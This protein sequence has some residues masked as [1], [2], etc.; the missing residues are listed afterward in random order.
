M[1]NRQQRRKLNKKVKTKLTPEEYQD[2]KN[3]VL[4]E[5]V[6]AEVDRRVK[7]MFESL[8]N[9]IIQSMKEHKIS[10]ARIGKIVD[11]VLEIGEERR[12]NEARVSE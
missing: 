9:D 5:T 10:E 4:D 1:A 11:R 7:E 6:K 12:K 2:Y 3:W 8:M